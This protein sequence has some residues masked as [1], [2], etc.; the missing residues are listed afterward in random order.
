MF[1]TILTDDGRI[2]SF[3][4]LENGSYLITL[5][6]EYINPNFNITTFETEPAISIFDTAINQY[7]LPR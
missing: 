3:R 7:A 1:E 4:L 5:K 6:P 2:E